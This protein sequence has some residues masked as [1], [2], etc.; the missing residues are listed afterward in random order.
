MKIWKMKC[1]LINGSLN[2]FQMSFG[3]N[4]PVLAANFT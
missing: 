2:Y 4:G 3:G 1:N